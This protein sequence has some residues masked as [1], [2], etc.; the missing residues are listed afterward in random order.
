MI[1]PRPP[2]ESTRLAALRAYGVLDTPPEPALDDLTALAAYVCGTPMS[3]ITLVDDERQWFKSAFGFGLRETARDVSFC[4]HMLHATTPVVVA[5]GTRDVRFAD[6]PFVTGEPGIRFYAAAPLRS[7]EGP[8]IGTLCVMDTVPRD[9]DDAQ[10]GALAAL[11]RQVMT[12]FEHK[13]IGRQLTEGEDQRRITARKSN[14]AAILEND[15][16]FEAE[17]RMRKL[18]RVYAMLSAINETIVRERRPDAILAAACRLAVETGGFRMS[19]IA[20]LEGGQ[21]GLRA[22]P[23]AD[24]GTLKTIRSL[25]E[26]EPPAGCAF[27]RHALATGRH[28]IC[29]DITNDPQSLS[30]RA[31]AEA[32]GYRSLAVLPLSG[33]AGVVG[34]F[35]IYAGEAGVFDAE[36]MSLL[37]ALAADISFALSVH[38]HEEERRQ[39]ERRFREVV[40]NIREVFW[41]TDGEYRQMIYVSPAYET[42]WGRSCESLYAAPH[43]WLDAVPDDDRERVAELARTKCAIGEFDD[44]YRIVQPGGATRWIRSRAFPVRAED[45][46]LERIVG[47]ATDITEQRHLEDQFRQA[48]KMESMGRLAGGIAHDFNNLLTVINGTTDLATLSL[49]ETHPLRADLAAIR[50][51]GERATTLTRQL[52]ALSRQQMLKPVV[53]NLS[54][55]VM[56]LREM[57]QRVLGED[58][59]LVVRAA[60]DL[61]SVKADPGQ[62]E[63]VVLNLAVNARDA[64]PDGGILTIE[65]RKV[66]AAYVA[67]TQG[68]TGTA[69]VQVSVSDTGVGMDDETR[70]HI[71]EPF[72]TTKELGKGTGLGLSTVYGIVQQSGGTVWVESAPGRGSTFTLQL[73]SVNEP[74]P[75]AVPAPAAP[76]ARGTETIL[77][78]ED[79]HALRALTRRVLESGGYTVLEAA[80]GADA[81]ARVQHHEGLL[82][83][84][85]T[86][87]VMPGMNGRELAGR[88]TGLR[89]DTKVLYASGYTNDAILRH[90]VLDAGSSFIS[91]PYTPTELQRRVRDVLDASGLSGSPSALASVSGEDTGMAPDTIGS[92]EIS[93]EAAPTDR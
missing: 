90:G 60:D 9:L 54:T 18:N 57:L 34:T 45:G 65:A 89:P 91:K 42:I 26:R 37:D 2:D 55:I 64:M 12:L 84:L 49:P 75:A 81:L 36:E 61:P 52:L 86:D 83:M 71:F 50:L 59:D 92:P 20:L 32:L 62:M 1:A 10:Q 19:T 56:G 72:F 51:A 66:P 85:F 39:G 13:R 73:P 47:F 28:A 40:E 79:E 67:D 14:E 93:Q 4:A 38:A 46:R 48:Q 22:H 35:A 30:W 33:A 27:T 3:L 77:L 43:S 76:P 24:D 15:K 82:H 25:I 74:L 88:I 63:Q 78:V 53:I 5:D 11:A 70:Q 68:V 17:Q 23:G 29:N 87:V 80:N 58:I 7:L 31:A 21:L 6:N 44:T 16:R 69:S 8:T 41:V